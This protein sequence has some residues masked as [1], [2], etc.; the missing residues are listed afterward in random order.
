VLEDKDGDG[1]FGTSP[2]GVCGG[3]FVGRPGRVLTTVGVYVI[4]RRRTFGNLTVDQGGITRR[5]LRR[6]VGIP[7]F[8]R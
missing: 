7:G 5:T 2:I 8:R 1:V 6:R 4:G 3:D